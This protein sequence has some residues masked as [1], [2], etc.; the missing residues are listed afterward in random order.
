MNDDENFFNQFHEAPRQEFVEALYQR[1]EKPMNAQK[2]QFPQRRLGLA[3][4]VAAMIL[5]AGLVSFPTIRAQAISLARQ[6]GAFLIV[7]SP[8]QATRTVNSAVIPQATAAPGETAGKALEAASVEEAARLSGFSVL[9]PFGLPEGYAQK[10]GFSILPNGDGKT[11]VSVYTNASRNTFLNL[12]QYQYQPGDAFVDTVAGQE[13][14]QDVTVRSHEG[15]WIT[16][17]YMTDPSRP[18][19][20][21]PE[22]L[23]PAN[24]LIWEENGIVYTLMG[25]DLSLEQ[26]L[27][28]AE[29]LR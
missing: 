14:L 19:Q 18:E 24:W 22:H 1:I 3:F 11:V 27:E 5:L 12:N 6:I 7:E 28:V 21:G 2:H 13:T 23:R 10:G 4:A 16:G 25:D 9:S 20:G 15:V 29:S 17:R 26:A 8:P